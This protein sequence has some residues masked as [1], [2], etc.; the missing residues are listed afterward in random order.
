MQREPLTIV[1]LI[2]KII[3]MI[4]RQKCEVFSRIVGYIRP[5]EQWNIGKKSEWED[6]KFFKMQ[7]SK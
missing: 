5:V 6:R 7:K 2:V 3:D 4:K 1:N